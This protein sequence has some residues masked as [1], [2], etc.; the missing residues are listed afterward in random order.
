M[1]ALL[2]SNFIL[3][4]FILRAQVDQNFPPPEVP[5]E[6]NAIKATNTIL[7]DGK[8]D[9]PDWQVGVPETDFFRRE[10]RQGG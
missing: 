7:V 2:I 6:I 8:L 10:P 5:L 3:I 4:S 1:R 9:E